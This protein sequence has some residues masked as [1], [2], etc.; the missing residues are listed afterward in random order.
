MRGLPAAARGYIGCATLAAA[1]CAAPASRLGAGCPLEQHPGPGHLVRTVRTAAPLPA[2][3]RPGAVRPGF[4]RSVRRLRRRLGQPRPARRGLS[5]AAAA[6]RAGRRPRRADR[7]YRGA[8]GRRPPALAR[9]R[10]GAGLLR[11]RPGLP[12]HRPPSAVRTAV[13]CSAAAGRGRRR[14]LLR[15]ARG[16]RRRCAGRRRAAPAAHR[17]AR[18]ADPFAGAASGARPGRADDGGPVAQL[19]RARGGAAG[20][21]ADVPLVLGL[22]PVPP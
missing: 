13:P 12:G 2:A 9:R 1:L 18:G 10:A 8:L 11:G 16:A 4:R 7:A 5:A 14:D 17:L 6:G 3:G 19:V 21:A 15:G 22:R 20:A